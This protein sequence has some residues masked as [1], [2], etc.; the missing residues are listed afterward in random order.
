MDEQR[1][2]KSTPRW[3]SE[4]ALKRVQ[5]GQRGLRRLWSQRTAEGYTRRRLSPVLSLV[6]RRRDGDLVRMTSHCI[7]WLHRVTWK[8]RMTVT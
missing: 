5:S 3:R 7:L 2:R 8:C 1:E 4:E 6:V